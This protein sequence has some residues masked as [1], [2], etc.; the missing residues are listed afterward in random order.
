MN[1]NGS[2]KLPKVIYFDTN[3][4]WPLSY[5]SSNV[6]FLKLKE[7]TNRFNIEWAIIETVLFEW[8][9]RLVRTAK[10]EVDNIN[11]SYKNIELLLNLKQDR[12]EYSNLH[13][14]SLF[15]KL[16][17]LMRSSH[18][19]YVDSPNN[20]EITDLLH[21]AAKYEVPFQ[22]E[23]KGFKDE[24]ILRTIINDMTSKKHDCCIFITNDNI[25]YEEAIKQ[26]LNKDGID[27]YLTRDFKQT[28]DLLAEIIKQKVNE[29]VSIKENQILSFLRSKQQEIFNY[30]VQNAQVSEEFLRSEHLLS[31]SDDKIFGDIVKIEEIKPIKISSAFTGLSLFK[32]QKALKPNEE[33]VTFTVE[34]GIK[35]FIR[36]YLI[37][38]KPKF[39]LSAPEQYEKVKNFPTPYYGNQTITEIKR[40]ISVSAILTKSNKKYSNYKITKILTY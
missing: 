36:P 14:K 17:L 15:N 25:F 16:I 6:E 12:I 33:D 11:K 2:K 32:K 21:S 29:Y 20:I 19:R 39:P 26:R 1:K 28:G 27:L 9:E 35:L 13:T 8:Y 18:I 30:V 24:I 38:N 31:R 10:E 4:I 40:Q 5:G 3:I 22:R 37:F 7:Y 23:D 34:T